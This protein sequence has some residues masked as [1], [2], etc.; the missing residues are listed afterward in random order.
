MRVFT[1]CFPPTA[2]T[3]AVVRG[4]GC[5][6]FANNAAQRLVYALECAEGCC[7]VPWVVTGELR[8]GVEGLEVPPPP[9]TTPSLAFV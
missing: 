1:V 9:T 2:V 3:W 8:K 5:E 6:A 7:P 4:V